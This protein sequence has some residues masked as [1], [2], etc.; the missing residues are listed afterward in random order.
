[1]TVT[2]NGI[3]RAD[4]DKLSRLFTELFENALV[5]AGPEVTV[6][7]EQFEDGFFVADDGPGV[8]PGER[9]QVFEYGYTTADDR[10][11]SG[12]TIA[13]TI[14][15]SLGWE[16]TVVGGTDGG[17]RFEITGVVFE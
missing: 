17:C 1:M 14:A 9:R 2:Y 8:Q 10:I 7:V 3:I 11:G 5:H 16:L 4:P 13:E 15:E 12:L 6:T